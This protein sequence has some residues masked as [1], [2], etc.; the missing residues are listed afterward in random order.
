MRNA[1]QQRLTFILLPAVPV[2]QHLLHTGVPKGMWD[3]SALACVAHAWL[4]GVP[5]LSR[6]RQLRLHSTLCRSWNLNFAVFLT[7]VWAFSSFCLFVYLTWISSTKIKGAGYV[8]SPQL[9]I[10]L[11]AVPELTVVELVRA[12]VTVRTGSQAQDFGSLW[13]VQPSSEAGWS[14]A[15]F[16]IFLCDRAG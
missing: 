7:P 10:S 6:V 5:R 1:F 9:P 13:V 12:M 4:A 14:S 3:E 15:I 16:R 8:P 2:A 11:C